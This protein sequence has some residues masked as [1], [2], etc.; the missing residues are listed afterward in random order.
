M[1]GQIEDTRN[2][3]LWVKVVGFTGNYN[4]TAEGVESWERP[5]GAP[6]LPG[7]A[8]DSAPGPDSPPLHIPLYLG[9]V[10]DGQG[11]MISSSSTVE[12]GRVLS[13]LPSPHSHLQMDKGN[14]CLPPPWA[15]FPSAPV[16]LGSLSVPLGR[17]S[18]FSTIKIIVFFPYEWLPV[19][20]RMELSSYALQRTLSRILYPS[21]SPS[22]QLQMLF[23]PTHHSLEPFYSSAALHVLFPLLGKP[24]ATLHSS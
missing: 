19:A 14:F 6:R 20:L 18:D 5:E 17:Q 2:R 11:K 1:L 4:G 12:P 16:T 8:G 13:N 15:T 7:G 9:T 22:C 24:L 21:C 3:Q 10:E 23:G